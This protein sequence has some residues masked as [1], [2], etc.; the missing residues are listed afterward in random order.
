MRRFLFLT[1]GI[2]ELLVAGVLAVFAWDLPGPATVTDSVN[3]VETVTRHAANEIHNLRDQARRLRERRP[4]I[5]RVS[6]QLEV[7]MRLAGELL[8]GQ[9]INTA[10]VGGVRDALGDVADGLDGFS[11]ALDP[12]GLG[13]IGNG[14]KSTAD[15]LED[16]VAPAAEKAADQLEKSTVALKADADRLKT[17]LEQTPPDLKAARAVV[18][19]MARFEEGLQLMSKLAGSDNFETIGDGLKGLEQSLDSSAG[20]VERF[21]DASVPQV[22]LTGGRVKLTQK[23]LWPEGKTIAEGMRRG[24]RGAGA[25]GKELETVRK[26]LPHL[27]ESLEQSR[28]VVS[29]T[30]QGLSAALEQQDKLDAVLKSIPSHANRLAEELPQMG[31][32][33]AAIL[34]DTSKL[35]DVARVLREAQKGIDVAVTR[36]PDLRKNL[37]QTATLL[38]STQTQLDTAL[39]NRAQYESAL[40]QTVELTDSVADLFPLLTAQL[41]DELERQEQSLTELGASIDR[42]S[43][44]LPAA[45]QTA[46]RLAF[47]A[48]VTLALMGLIVTLHGIHVVTGRGRPHVHQTRTV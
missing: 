30:R 36:W 34:R 29:A 40:R 25:A 21:S 13:Q 24:A 23:D 43:D 4:Q 2:L 48:R 44:T 35:K 20:Q 6:R 22:K 17:L 12:N 3:R 47:L 11:S 18:D 31:K 15:Y 28:K 38:R 27:R 46:S 39:R 33:L 45:G 32:D 16:S 26:E 8:R 7:Q 37:G 1:L 14:L 42:F 9:Q 41:G 5:E 10:T 19:G